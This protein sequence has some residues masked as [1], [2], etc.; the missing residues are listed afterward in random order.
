MASFKLDFQR[1]SGSAR[2]FGWAMLCAGLAAAIA[3]AYL[4]QAQEQR[5]DEVAALKEQL[6]RSERALRERSDS[7][8]TPEQQ[9]ERERLAQWSH[10]ALTPLKVVELSWSDQ[11][12]MQQLTL[13]RDD[14]ALVIEFEASSLKEGMDL[15]RRLLKSDFFR[16]VRLLRHAMANNG[17]PNAV[18]MA[19][20]LHWGAAK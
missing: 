13:S 5:A 16:E 1:P 8:E 6:A 14:G 3:V 20:E 15:H 7:S 19:I 17:G 18:L 4:A 10:L 12:T 9:A 2:W 11:L